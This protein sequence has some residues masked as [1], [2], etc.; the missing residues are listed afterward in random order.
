MIITA[1]V[2]SLLTV[3]FVAAAAAADAQTGGLRGRVVD[4]AGKPVADAEVTFDYES[5]QA[6][7]YTVKTNANGEWARGGLRTAG[8]WTITVRKDTLVGRV[9]GIE[10]PLGGVVSVKDIVARPGAISAPALKADE[11]ALRAQTEQAELGAAL[12]EANAAM[13]AGNYDQVIARFTD[14][15]AKSKACSACYVRI[16]DAYLKKKDADAAEKAYL[17]AIE[18]DGTSQNAADA[19]GALAG[20]YNEQRKLA[21]AA[22]MSQK[23][24]ELRG[25]S[26]GG[27]AT[28]IFNAAAILWN[29][30]KVAEAKPQFEKV[31]QLNPKMAEAHYYLGMCLVSENKMAE[32]KAALE[33]YL[34]LAPNGPNAAT[35]KAVIDAAK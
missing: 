12:N 15:A 32:A 22:K 33:Q 26:G 10:A 34:K 4:E 21:D 35:A 29:Q 31:I 18:V 5:G 7:R 24:A 16:G 23:E 19:Y 9:T 25:A 28:S 11:A 27:D 17:K 3:V 13:A 20:L 1:L 14:L 8:S 2:R 6:L 30:G